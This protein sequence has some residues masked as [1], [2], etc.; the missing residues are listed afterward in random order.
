MSDLKFRCTAAKDFRPM[1]NAVAFEMDADVQYF[2]GWLN[3]VSI[4]ML[5][6]YIG[7]NPI[8]GKNYVALRTAIIEVLGKC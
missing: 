5:G 3:G 7:M 4:H 2:H 6:K 8:F 1:I